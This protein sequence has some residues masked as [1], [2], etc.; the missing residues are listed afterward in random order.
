MSGFAIFLIISLTSGSFGFTPAISPDGKKVVFS[1]DGDLWI[2]EDSVARRLTDSKGYEISPIWS[3]DGRK[4][5]FASNRYGS[6]D[7]FVIPS[8]GSDRPV[9][10]TFHPGYEDPLFVSHDT[11]YFSSWRYEF[12]GAV[13]KIP[14]NGGTPELAWN[15]NVNHMVPGPGDT[16]IFERGS[17]PSWRRKYR[18]PANRDI[19][20]MTP[21]TKFMKKLTDFE[22]RDAYPMYSKFDGKIYFVSN[23]NPENVANLFVMNTD[24]SNRHQLTH[25]KDDVIWPSI[26]EDGKSIVFSVLGKLYI[27]RVN[28]GTVRQLTIKV[29]ADKKFSDP[30]YRTLKSRASEISISPD[31]KELA[32]VVFGD[33]FVKNLESGEIKRVTCTPEPEKDISWCGKKI[34]FTSL[35]DGNWNLYEA[36]PVDDSLFSEA[37]EFHIKRITS[38]KGTEKKPLC[39]PDGKKIA[40]L[41]DQGTLNVLDS[42]G[43][44]K[45]YSQFN[46]VVWI[47]WSPD[48]KWLAFSRTALGWREDIYVV[49]VDSSM[50]PVNISNHPNDDYRPLWS[51]DGRRIA[52]AS[53]DENGNLS[54][55]YVILRKEDAGKTPD[56]FKTL[57]DSSPGNV[58]IDFEDIGERIH[59]VYTF[60]GGYNYFNQDKWGLRFLVQAEDLNSNDIWMVDLAGDDVKRIT[61]NSVSPKMFFFSP[62]G[63][64]IYYLTENGKIFKA[65]PNGESSPIP[66]TIKLLIDNAKFRRALM[67]QLWWA[68]YDGFYDPHFHGIDWKAMFKKYLP[69]ATSAYENRDFYIFVRFMLGEIN[70]SHLGIWGSGNDFSE[71]TGL[72]GIVPEK[73]KEGYRIKR[74]IY[75]SPAFIKNLKPGDII[76]KIDGVKLD[77]VLNFY[78]ALVGKRNKKVKIIVKNSGTDTLKI[79][80]V[81]YG[82]IRDLIYREWVKKNREFVDSISHGTLAYIHLIGMNLRTVKQFKRELYEQLDKKG[83]ILDIRYNGGGS[84]HD[85]ILNIL[86][87]T[88]YLYSIDRGEKKKEYSS[89]FSWNKPVVLLINSQCYSDAEIFPAGFKQLKLGIVVGTPT[90]GAVIGTNDITLF[91]GETV[92][93]VPSEGWYTL[94]GKNL[95][96]GPVHPDIYVE[97][98]PLFDNT[99]GDPQ[100]RKAVEVMLQQIKK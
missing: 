17:T 12:R 22:G 14:I 64:K 82:K 4:I 49:K 80:P 28:T 87:R 60:K 65:T 53:R 41:T 42:E 36:T 59:T 81:S 2:L 23:D 48:S 35:V 3:P 33:I 94:E 61:K 100:L 44:V 68:L 95:E 16:L 20:I 93:R 62:D 11:V 91:D 27:Y 63:E 7:L 47:S 21:D 9:R 86:R 57:K 98:P 66:F 43:N 18:G 26:S 71:N 50:E 85:I 69:Y 75:N 97:N 79:K 24:G 1:Y 39:S 29:S 38:R 70:A 51:S 84:T 99:T 73:V 5:V 77:T 15:F 52:F 31:G 58:R 74:V 30:Y 54:I 6:W 67:M 32:F 40:F 37:T 90:F 83:L 55:K 78:S 8:D 89:L 76:T 10:L 96:L 13:Y 92:F 45:R 34:I 72:L 88:H 56:Y 19:W 25:F 46:D